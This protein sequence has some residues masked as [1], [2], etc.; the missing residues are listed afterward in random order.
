MKHESIY[1]KAACENHQ[2]ENISKQPWLPKGL[3][4]LA[5]STTAVQQRLSAGF[6][7]LE[8]SYGELCTQ[9]EHAQGKPLLN[10]ENCR[11]DHKKVAV[12]FAELTEAV[13]ACSGLQRVGEEV[14]D[15]LFSYYGASFGKNLEVG[16]AALVEALLRDHV[17]PFDVFAEASQKAPKMLYFLTHNTILPWLQHYA[18]FAMSAHSEEPWA[19]GHCPVCAGPAFFGYWSHHLPDQEHKL[20]L[21]GDYEEGR[22]NY[23]F[24]TCNFCRSTFVVKK[25]Q[26]PF[27]LESDSKKL[28]YFVSEEMRTIQIHTCATCKSYIKVSDIRER[29]AKR[30]S[31]ALEDL[32][33]LPLDFAAAEQGY[34]RPGASPWGL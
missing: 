19:H 26:C 13:S 22:R 11:F 7:P 18:F 9:A 8:L 5:Q 30:I 1:N 28:R 6:T 25:V 27:C 31:P 33:S 32:A 2:L 16:T 17:E 3:L 23:R 24:H 21:K 20:M 14:K 4:E 34:G 15:F 10:F 29:V 12:A